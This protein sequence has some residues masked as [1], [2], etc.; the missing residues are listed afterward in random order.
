VPHTYDPDH[1]PVLPPE[2][3][4]AGSKPLPPPSRY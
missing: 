4:E 1:S 3:A 2:L